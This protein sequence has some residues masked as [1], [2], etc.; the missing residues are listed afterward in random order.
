MDRPSKI[1]PII[2]FSQFAGTSLWF[3]GNA[4]LADVQVSWDLGGA[5]LGW[6]TS[7]V[8]LGFIAG[9]FLFAMLSIVDRYSPPLIFL[10]CSLAG[11]FS[12]YLILVLDGNLQNLVI[13]RFCTGFFLAGI[14]PVG[15]KIAAGW[16]QK[17][18]GRA[19]GYL[20]GAL[21]AGTAFP[22]LVKGL[23]K[24]LPWETVIISVSTLAATGGIAMFIFVKNG[25]YHNS[26]SRFEWSAVKRVFKVKEFR[27]AA[28]GYFGHMW[29][30]Y[31]LWTFIPF[32]L[33]NYSQRNDYE[34]NIPL[35]SFLIIG[36]GALGCVIGGLI[37]NKM[38][39]A[40]VAYMF[41]LTSGICCLLSIFLIELPFLLFISMLLIWGF[42]VVADSP[43]F[44]TL[45]ALTSPPQLVGTGLTIVTSIGFSISILSIEL[46]NILKEY[47]DPRWIF[48]V[49]IPG[50]V[51]GLRALRYILAK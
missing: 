20:V 10:T 39:S 36:S 11:A 19:L 13:L 50:P 14:Y 43:Q 38:G 32:I 33:A 12:N 1:L 37:S 23:G 40:K 5:S 46:L 7:A 47:T 21:V 27:S 9:T 51:F 18:L 25:P 49:L 3:A 48:L 15:M 6:I 16:Y 2:I 31:A 41:L 35:I 4:I 8:Q 34:F 42:T 26:S 29:E 24:G 45:N 30:L 28:F 17:G 44:S 22:H